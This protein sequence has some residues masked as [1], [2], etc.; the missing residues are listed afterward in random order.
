MVTSRMASLRRRRRRAA[1]ARKGSRA[2]L[3]AKP[4]STRS[5]QASFCERGATGNGGD[6]GSGLEPRRRRKDRGR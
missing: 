4:K 1:S 6:Q 3:S 5:F 2:S